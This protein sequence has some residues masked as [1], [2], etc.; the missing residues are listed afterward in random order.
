M[1][2][3]LTKL[4]LTIDHVA[5]ECATSFGS[6]LGHRNGVW[7][8]ITFCSDVGIDYF[9]LA[10]GDPREVERL[11]ALGGTDPVLLRHGTPELSSPGWF[12]LGEERIKFTALSRTSLRICPSCLAKGR[13]LT[14][15]AHLGSW[16]LT[17]IRHCAVHG[18]QLISLPKM[19]NGNDTFDI[20]RAVEGF[21]PVD[22]YYAMVEDLELEHYL[23]DRIAG[24]AKGGW[25]DVL[26]FHVAS[27]TCEMFG[28]LLSQGP[29][30]KRER[31]GPPEWAAAGTAGFRILR[32][33]AD[34]FR[35]ELKA[36]QKASPLDNTLYRTRFRVFFE[37]LRYRDDD[38]DFDVIRNIVRQFIF[39]NFPVAA[40]DMV[41][42]QPCPEQRV[43]SLMTA[44]TA[45]GV[46]P[47]RLGRR[48][49]AIG[50][51]RRN[52][53]NSMFVID[54]YI[55]A[56][57]VRSVVTE[58]D[59]LVNATDAAKIIG[60]DRI[61]MAKLTQQ[62]LISRFYDDPNTVPLYHPAEL[63]T[64][65]RR[66]REQISSGEPPAD[67]CSIGAAAHKLS[68]PVARVVEVILDQGI[69]LHAS[70]CTTAALRDFIVSLEVLR[71]TFAK[72]L[73][74]AISP[75][76]ASK[77]LG[78]NIRTIRGL[79]DKG[80]LVPRTIK[81]RSSARTRRYASRRSV[82]DFRSRYISVM[83]LAAQTGRLPSVEAV[84][85]ADRGVQPLELNGRSNLIFRRCDVGLERQ[86]SIG[87]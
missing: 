12:R 6:R 79:L 18:C 33:G 43:H 84:L 29:D 3:R 57:I 1:F 64:F 58:I 46:S 56:D 63:A 36:V 10:N 13:H 15:A 2:G 75:V 24:S 39:D 60:T 77:L 26:P 19:S 59:A 21:M 72:R 38:P 83:D 53:A 34:A 32:Q 27:Q 41:L 17:S 82:D 67:H 8:L 66:L 37:C 52:S 30:A 86:K 78:L 55:P 20:M 35:S 51:A 23:S 87:D 16:Q 11:A 69:H 22:P 40:G 74:D 85:Q 42:G 62:G 25:L 70:D 49:A 47:W 9:A 4:P 44:R 81:D 61:T 54:D 65:L 80:I 28:L 14:H 7:R 68:T 50:L 5:G 31:I 76:E 45:Y 71:Q 48:L 73:D